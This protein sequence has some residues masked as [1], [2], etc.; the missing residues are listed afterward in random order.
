MPVGRT[1]ASVSGT[2]ACFQKRLLPAALSVLL[3]PSLPSPSCSNTCN[4]GLSGPH[5]H[6]HHFTQ[7]CTTLPSTVHYPGLLL[8]RGAP[9]HCGSDLMQRKGTALKIGLMWAINPVHVLSRSAARRRWGAQLG[10]LESCVQMGSLLRWECAAI[11]AMQ[12]KS[13]LLWDRLESCFCKGS[14]LAK[15]Q[16]LNTAELVHRVTLV[17]HPA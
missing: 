9:I 2:C 1:E 11:W 13:S 5:L 12:P 8:I 14:S 3:P 16:V 10:S 15:I 7:S 17:V 6:E 4:L